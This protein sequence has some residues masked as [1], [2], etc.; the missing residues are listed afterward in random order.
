MR[1]ITLSVFM[2]IFS[3]QHTSSR[4]SS[5]NS[6]CWLENCNF[7]PLEVLEF[8]CVLG[9]PRSNSPCFTDVAFSLA[10][11]Y[12]L[13]TN[14]TW[15]I[16]LPY[17]SL[18]TFSKSDYLLEDKIQCKAF[19]KVSLCRCKSVLNVCWIGNFQ[20]GPVNYIN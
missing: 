19:T 10:Q 13:S 6:R 5:P 15:Q 12:F 11:N 17:I 8:S 9:T 2:L 4:P 18:N 20:R 7:L 3:N 16:S 1:L 14:H